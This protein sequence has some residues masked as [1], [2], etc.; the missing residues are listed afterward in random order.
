M[1]EAKYSNIVLGAVLDS[2]YWG[3][4]GVPS[5]QSGRCRVSLKTPEPIH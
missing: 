3:C 4:H 1:Y 5:N 2:Q